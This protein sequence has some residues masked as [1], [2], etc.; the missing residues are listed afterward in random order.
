MEKYKKQILKFYYKGDFIFDIKIKKN[1]YDIT[2]TKVYSYINKIFKIHINKNKINGCNNYFEFLEKIGIKLQK[3]NFCSDY[4]FLNILYGRV[5]NIINL[6]LI[7]YPQK[8]YCKNRLKKC[9]GAKLNPNSIKFVSLKNNITEDEALKYIKNRNKS[10]FYKENFTNENE[11]KKSQTRDL[12]FYIN[13]YG[14]ENGNNK[15]N[16]YLK[17]LKY[18]HSE[19][20]YIDLLGEIK[21]KEHQKFLS[22]LKD[23][24]S[25][26][27]FLKL[28]NNDIN[29]AKEEY[30]KRKLQVVNT[31]QRF[32]ERHGILIGTEKYN[33]KCNDYKN[34]ITKYYGELKANCNNVSK[35]SILFFDK[36]KIKLINMKILNDDDI[37]QYGIKNEK[38]IHNE[39]TGTCYF[40]D[41]YI[42]KYNILLEY[43]GIKQHPKSINDI[44]YK[45]PYN[46]I[47]TTE[48]FYKRDEHKKLTAEK[49]N[50]NIIY[51]QEDDKNKL[52]NCIK[53]IINIINYEK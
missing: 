15:Y 25:Y 51:I 7:E 39:L 9:P 17:K 48:F 2:E 10:P 11:Y 37:I 30:N 43:N 6:D 44:N 13:K 53:N 49:Y 26:N 27:Y 31:L 50:Y 33:K 22:E 35:S 36:L 40:Y 41:C 24:M 32:I 34:F 21:G 38:A 5:D 16:N 1:I 14:I 23:N 28:Y 47:N 29:K 45:H 12:N 46:K 3:C 19:Q 18:S 52:N 20:Y 8:F 4:A 42:H